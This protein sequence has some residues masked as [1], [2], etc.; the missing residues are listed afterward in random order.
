MRNAGVLCYIFFGCRCACML[1]V[2]LAACSFA[3]SLLVVGRFCAC[4]DVAFFFAPCHF[5]HPF[6]LFPLCLL[7]WIPCRL[8]VRHVRSLRPKAK[9][10]PC[11][12][13]LAYACTYMVRSIK[14]KGQK[15]ENPGTQVF[16]TYV[17]H[18]RGMVEPL[19]CCH[20]H[21]I[22]GSWPLSTLL[23]YSFGRY[24]RH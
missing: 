14:E 5:T 4:M 7:G 17:S 20:F 24:G 6:F 16:R 21:T 22:I 15:I 3:C 10:N 1:V 23:A 2:L 9:A 12:V 19:R 18:C 8:G 11:V 13:T